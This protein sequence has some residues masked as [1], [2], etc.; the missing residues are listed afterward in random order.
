MPYYED[1]IDK[2]VNGYKMVHHMGE[3]FYVDR[4]TNITYM[5]CSFYK[6]EDEEPERA[7]RLEEVGTY[8]KECSRIVFR[9]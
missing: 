8:D 7:W 4:N 9:N 1:D 2:L 3:T 6:S 5:L